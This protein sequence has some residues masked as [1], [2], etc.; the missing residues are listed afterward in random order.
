[1]C[2]GLNCCDKL[3]RTTRRLGRI[4]Y[5]NTPVR[6]LCADEFLFKLRNVFLQNSHQFLSM[7]FST[8]V[9]GR[10]TDSDNKFSQVT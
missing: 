8:S 10:T 6:Q 9:P 2:F 7:R 1:M 4:T 5:D 3:D